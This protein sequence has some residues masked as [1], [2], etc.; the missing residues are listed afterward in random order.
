MQPTLSTVATTE[1]DGQFDLGQL[2]MQR[3]R[4]GDDA[5]PDSAPVETP[6]TPDV[7]PDTGNPPA[8]PA[9]TP[10]EHPSEVPCEPGPCRW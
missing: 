10:H 2:T 3:P 4:M 9:P 8:D 7:E 1:S 5:E 6:T